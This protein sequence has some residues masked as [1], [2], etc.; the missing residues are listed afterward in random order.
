MYK[1][2]LLFN[3][4][5]NKIETFAN[6]IKCLIQSLTNILLKYC[7]SIVNLFYKKL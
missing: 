6:E 4:N 3:F 5:T 1:R 7:Q 2:N